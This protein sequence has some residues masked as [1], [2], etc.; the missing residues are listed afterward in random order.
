MWLRHRRPADQRRHR[1]RGSA[2]DDVQRRDAL[3]PHR[4]DADVVDV[5]G[6][7]EP[8]GERIDEE[9][10]ERE[11]RARRRRRRRS[12]RR[13][14]RFVLAGSGRF[15][16][17]FITRSMSASHTQ[18]NAPADAAASAPP[19]SVQKSS[20]GARNAAR[21]HHHRRGGR[22]E[23]QHDDARLR[24][25]VVVARGAR[26]RHRRGRA[27]MHRARGRVRRRSS[28]RPPRRR[29]PG[30]ASAALTACASRRSS[31]TAAR[32]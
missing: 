13:A 23:Q 26:D 27:R 28:R 14:A 10:E 11:R 19:S 20:A 25:F 18:L 8:C 30:R 15:A 24:E 3:E 32:R 12:S 4:V 16:V 5:S 7:R 29:T 31:A 2:D 17:R 9:V 22:D 6:Q 21:G 1:A